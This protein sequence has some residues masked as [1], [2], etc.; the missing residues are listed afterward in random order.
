MIQPLTP[1]WRN[2]IFPLP[3]GIS[4]IY[5]LVRCQALSLLLKAGILFG[6]HQ[7]WSCAWHHYYWVFKW[8]QHC[9][10][11]K[12]LFSFKS[13]M[14]SG[15]YN[16]PLPLP[17]RFLSLE[18]DIL[19]RFL[20]QFFSYYSEQSDSVLLIFLNKFSN[21]HLISKIT[22][23]PNGFFKETPTSNVNIMYLPTSTNSKT[24]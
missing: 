13:P 10:V 11:L 14:T 8:H 3:A 12:K 15:A 7:Y 23:S 6:L 9:C 19:M 2:W 5:I 16:L 18:S 20:S 22:Q 17:H 1:D 21:K 4:C 24:Y